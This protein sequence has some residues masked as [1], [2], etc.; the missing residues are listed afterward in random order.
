LPESARQVLSVLSELDEPIHQDLVSALL[1]EALGRHVARRGLGSLER[2]GLL[3][4]GEVDDELVMGLMPPLAR[5]LRALFDARH[6]QVS[7]PGRRSAEEAASGSEPADADR[8]IM[9]VVW[10][11]LANH[12]PRLTQRGDLY[13]AEQKKLK[14]LFSSLKVEKINTAL[15]WLGEFDLWDHDADGRLR[16]QAERVVGLL[17]QPTAFADGLRLIQRFGDRDAIPCLGVLSLLLRRPGWVQAEILTAVLCLKWLQHQTEDEYPSY[18]HPSYLWQI[19]QNLLKG[20]VR[21]G[22]I[23]RSGKGARF[24]QTD[25]LRGLQSMLRAIG[26]KKDPAPTTRAVCHLQPNFEILVPPECP[27]ET[28]FSVGRLG[29]LVQLDQVATFRLTE[30]SLHSALAQGLR[31]PDVLDLLQRVSKHGL[32]AN[33]AQ[34]L[35]DFAASLRIGH[36]LRGTVV[37]LPDGQPPGAAEKYLTP[38]AVPGV[39]LL[40]EHLEN[41]CF[42]ALEKSG[43]ALT[44]QFAEEPF[45]A[46]HGRR[47]RHDRWFELED[48]RRE[49]NLLAAADHGFSPDALNWPASPREPGADQSATRARPEI[50]QQPVVRLLFEALFH[51]PKSWRRHLAEELFD[52][53]GMDLQELAGRLLCD[54]ASLDDCLEVVSE[55]YAYRG[56]PPILGPEAAQAA[57]DRRH[58]V[59]LV[60]C[61]GGDLIRLRPRRL[62]ERRQTV[63]LTGNLVPEGDELPFDLRDFLVGFGPAT[64]TKAGAVSGHSTSK[65]GR[66]DPCPCGSGKKYK[67]CCQPLKRQTSARDAG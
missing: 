8:F 4:H 24:R 54:P 55:G 50:A 22:W 62:D 7:G 16:I 38:S 14:A 25:R 45:F 20:L 1:E 53:A 56:L 49:L 42:K 46:E 35:A 37:I 10:A 58:D 61:H 40:Q 21:D 39:Y 44:H 15:S 59:L 26:N 60:N 65:V 19:A 33:V 51:A 27:P 36:V 29:S 18:L 52:D 32:P 2:A 66:N 17:G 30:Q 3:L 41:R 11:H 5:A 67:K 23:E 43:T 6:Q 31:L 64:G 47:M 48:A 13:A 12:R 28:V 9:A 63:V 34:G 57:I